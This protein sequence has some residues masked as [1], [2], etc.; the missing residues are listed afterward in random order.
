MS[1]P[2]HEPT[3]VAVRSKYGKPLGNEHAYKVCNEVAWIHRAEGFGLRRKTTGNNYNGFAVDIVFHKPSNT[4]VDILAD[5][6][7]A[8]IPQWSEVGPGNPD[9]WVAPTDPNGGP[10]PPT[11]LQTRVLALEDDLMRLREALTGWIIK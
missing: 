7:N 11:D 9:E 5:S 2:N 1:V 4:L 8:G 10:P 3:V 6:E